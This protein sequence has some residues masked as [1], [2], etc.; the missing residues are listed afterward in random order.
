MVRS[1]SPWSYIGAV[2]L[3]LIIAI[4]LYWLFTILAPPPAG[5]SEETA[6]Q[7]VNRSAQEADAEEDEQ[8]GKHDEQHQSAD[9]QPASDDSAADGA[10]SSDQLAESD[11]LSEDGA[12]ED[13]LISLN[14]ANSEQLQLLPG[15]GPAKA[16]AILDYRRTHGAFESLD[17]LL[18]V[19]G[20]GE[21]TLEKLKPLLK[22]D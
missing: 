18:Y 19:K 10:E 20:I 11:T 9:S 7:P 14:R 5:W 3:F 4:I 12:G 17:E 6:W 13:S 22:L 8:A 1:R 15:I 21:K 16:Q 2:G